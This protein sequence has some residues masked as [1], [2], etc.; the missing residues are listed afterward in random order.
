MNSIEEVVDLGPKF[1]RSPIGDA[2]GL[3]QDHVPVVD[4]WTCEA[5]APKIASPAK[6]SVSEKP[7]IWTG[8][9]AGVAY[10]DRGAVRIEIRTLN[11]PSVRCV[12]VREDIER[13][14]AG[15]GRN[16]GELPAFEDPT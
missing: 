1:Q 2:D 8:L 3:L 9:C 5:I 14:A 12:Q 16:A 7:E 15:E 6:W 13:K 4:S 11:F 10:R